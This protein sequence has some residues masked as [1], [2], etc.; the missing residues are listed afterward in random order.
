M[1]H[2]GSR[3]DGWL[4]RSCLGGRPV[5]ELAGLALSLRVFKQRIQF[6]RR[7]VLIHLPGP[8]LV[9]TPVDPGHQPVEISRG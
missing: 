3:N 9:V 1:T 8:P 4:W 2:K 7:R 6:A 5:Q